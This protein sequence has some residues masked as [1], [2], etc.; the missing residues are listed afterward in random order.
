[1][2]ERNEFIDSYLQWYRS[3]VAARTDATLAAFIALRLVTADVL[4]TFGS[5]RSL[6]SR[7]TAQEASETLSHAIEKWR[8]FWCYD[9][10]GGHHSHCETLKLRLSTDQCHVFLVSFF[11][12][13]AQLVI[14]AFQLQASVADRPRA[15][16]EANEKLMA[17]YDG[18]LEMLHIISDQSF[19]SRLVFCHDSIHTMIAY[20][21]SLLI[22]LLLS[23]DSTAR[24]ALEYTV[25]QSIT[26]VAAN[27]RRQATPPTFACSMLADYLDNVLSEY[28]KVTHRASSSSHRNEPSDH[29]TLGSV[30]QRHGNDI[31]RQPYTALDQHT[32]PT[33][34]FHE[35]STT[36]PAIEAFESSQIGTQH[37]SG[38]SWTYADEDGWLAMFSDAGLNVEG[39]V[40]M[41]N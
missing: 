1:M 14:R 11:G 12:A 26:T 3:P 41:P 40:F 22:K 31:A 33:A 5:L 6:A 9:H 10:S 32:I 20:A 13:H 21:A 2:I 34:G 4:R 7:G 18:A 36:P 25:T 28:N 19:A 23:T 39:G 15:N 37:A 29:D 24:T 8:N 16:I 30:Y 35:T 27:F 38:Y 17:A